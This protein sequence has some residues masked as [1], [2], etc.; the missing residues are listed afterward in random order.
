MATILG[1]LVLGVAFLASVTHPVPYQSGT[2][3]V[4]SQVA[5]FV[6]GAGGLGN[7]VLRLLQVATMLI[8]VLAANTSFTGFPFLASFA[9][10]DSYLPR[11]LTRRGHRLVFSTGIIVLTVVA[12]VLLW[13]TQAKVDKLIPLYAIG[14]F[15]G[16]T[17][18]GAGMVKYHLTHREDHWRRRLAIN[19]TAS[20]LSFI[21]LIIIAVAKFTEGA[22]VVV[23]ILPLGVLVLLRLHRQ[24]VER[25]AAARGGSGR[26]GRGAGAQPPRGGRAGRPAG[27]GHRPG[28]PVRPDPPPRRAP[29]RPLRPRPPG[30]R[31]SSRRSGAGSACPGSRS[32]S[33]SARTGA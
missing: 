17:M 25:G 11:Q 3:T 29:G 23:V 14:V 13:I 15:T 16:F 28:P 4:I 27:H 2:P 10:E 18:A 20:V 12:L 21:V 24:Y 26:G 8:L 19:G 30:P 5:K 9:A 32:T 1:S 6:Y 31:P 33:R 22:W 7:R